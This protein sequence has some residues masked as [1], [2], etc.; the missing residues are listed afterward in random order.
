MPKVYVTQENPALNYLP[1][2]E[3][4][5]VVFL[6]RDD[7]NPIKNSLANEA[8]L[9]DLQR[10][11]KAFLPDDDFMVISGSPVVSA[12]VFMLLRDRTNR[13]KILR[14][15]NRDRIYQPLHLQLPT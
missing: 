15:S 9:A 5:E 13:V 12:A 11:L 10:K 14:W 1:A 8:L 3:F 7:F 2:E 4:G 6:T